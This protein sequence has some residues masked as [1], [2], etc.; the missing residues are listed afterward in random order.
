MINRDEL[1]DRLEQEGAFEIYR[2]ASDGPRSGKVW[3]TEAERDE[4]VAALRG[5]PEDHLRCCG[6][7]EPQYNCPE[8]VRSTT[9]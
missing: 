4:I 5:E 1:A 2:G 6:T 9:E 3:M 7:P 8:T